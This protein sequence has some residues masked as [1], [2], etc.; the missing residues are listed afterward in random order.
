M[1]N[2][3]KKTLMLEPFT[4]KDLS[5]RCLADRIKDIDRLVTLYPNLHKNEAFG[6]HLMPPVKGNFEHKSII[7]GIYN[8]LYLTDANLPGDYVK[9]ELVMVIKNNNQPTS[10]PESHL[11]NRYVD[12]NTHMVLTII[13]S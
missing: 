6:K 1:S 3:T 10:R 11:Y 9:S 8:N 7:D 4:H 12:K 13:I 2:G 5:K